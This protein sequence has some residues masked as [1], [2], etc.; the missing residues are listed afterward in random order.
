MKKAVLYI[1]ACIVFM[2]AVHV[3]AKAQQKEKH[4]AFLT[5]EYNKQLDKESFQ[6]WLYVS[7]AA[8]VHNGDEVKVLEKVP[9]DHELGKSM[10]T[11]G[12]LEEIRNHYSK[13]YG[14]E[15][16][17]KSGEQFNDEDMAILVNQSKF[18]SLPPNFASAFEVG[19]IGAET[20]NIKYQSRSER[21]KEYALTLDGSPDVLTS[22]G[23]T[24][25]PKDVPKSRPN[26]PRKTVYEEDE[27]EDE[28]IF[29]TA[30][31]TTIVNKNKVVSENRG[32]REDVGYS[33]ERPID[34]HVNVET[35]T[36]D[37]RTYEIERK[38]LRQGTWNTVFNG[39]SALSA[40][41]VA[42]WGQTINLKQKNFTSFKR[43][44][45]RVPIDYDPNDPYY[46]DDPDFQGPAPSIRDRYGNIVRGYDDYGYD[47]YGYGDDG[48]IYEDDYYDDGNGSGGF[49]D[50]ILGGNSNTWGKRQRS[51]GGAN[52][53]ATNSRKR[54]N[55]L[56]MYSNNQ[57]PRLARRVPVNQRRVASVQGGRSTQERNRRF[58]VDDQN[59]LSN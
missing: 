28:E 3:S 14:K 51:G 30:G 2:L 47:D 16:G 21:G 15:E 38:K 54:V 23:N 6:Y 35:G 19:M 25:R 44:G 32:T 46:Y 41:K 57:Q 58:R 9:G 40:A 26:K 50:Q 22:C 52:I 49:V 10:W 33:R 17:L 4:H 24:V 7:Y 20:G 29:H 55:D 36:M 59:V 45:R 27:Y 18:M 1:S 42:I 37:D 5:P 39:I 43:G 8:M 11:E 13:K 34:V 31:N 12:A 48:Y 53:V 56:R